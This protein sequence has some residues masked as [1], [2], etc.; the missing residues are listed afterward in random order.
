MSVGIQF[1]TILHS[2]NEQKVHCTYFTW[3]QS[4]QLNKITKKN[5]SVSTTTLHCSMCH[6]SEII[7]HFNLKFNVFVVSIPDPFK[8]KLVIYSYAFIITHHTSAF[9]YYYGAI[10]QSFI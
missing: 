7:K 6:R 2:Y 1:Y 4:L 8:I 10:A 3:Y 9:Y 5:L